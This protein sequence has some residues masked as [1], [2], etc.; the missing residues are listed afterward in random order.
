[1]PCLQLRVTGAADGLHLRSFL[2]ESGLASSVTVTIQTDSSAGKSI[3]SQHGVSR[4]TR[5]VQL[6]YLFLL[7]LVDAGIIKLKNIDGM[8]N[9][10][11]IFTKHVK[12]D[13]L[14]KHLKEVGITSSV[15]KR[16][17]GMLI[18]TPN[19]ETLKPEYYN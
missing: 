5:H 19:P 18:H 17:I 9:C 15:D 14:Q 13:V 11:D 2:F 8:M 4:R 7:E 10:A 1:M 3:A 12:A 6:R 16:Y